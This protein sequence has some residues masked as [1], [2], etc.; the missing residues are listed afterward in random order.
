MAR[1]PFLLMLSAMYENGGN[2]VHRLLDG[3]P[4]LLVYPFESQVGTRLVSDLLTSTFPVKYRWPVFRLGATP[5]EHYRA[6]I[7][8]EAKVRTITPESSKFKDAPFHMS[9][10]DR[11][12][13][14]ERALAH[15]PHSTG[16]IVRTFFQATFEAWRNCRRPDLPAAYVGYSPAI[17][18]D[19]PRILADLTDAHVAHVV[20]NPW[21]AYADTKRRAVPLP[22]LEYMRGW[23][24][25]QQHALAY[26][27]LYSDRVHLLR[28]EDVTADPT[29]VL[30]DFCARLGLDGS[31]TLGETTWNGQSMN[32]VPPWG[33][34]NSRT[35]DSNRERAASLSPE[36]QRTIAAMAGPLLDVLGYRNYLSNR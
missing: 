14:F 32:A 15:R 6:I 29:R 25:N 11:L 28:F 17:V 7:D 36:E 4:Q 13:A 26:R 3:H 12:A 16:E 27:E 23:I 22:V 21:S 30:G 1:S 10:A 33:V 31:D 20:R 24:I 18:V 19:A 5:A 8:E 2:T 9:D 35:P 34:V